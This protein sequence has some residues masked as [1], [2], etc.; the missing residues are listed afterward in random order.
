[1]IMISL[2]VWNST[3]SPPDSGKQPQRAIEASKAVIL[4]GL[5]SESPNLAFSQS[6]TN[7]L[8]AAGYEVDDFRGDNVT[9]DLL[10]NIANYS[11][12]IL[13]LHSTLDKYGNLYIFSGEPYT[14]SKYAME[15][16]T[17]SVRKA[18]TFDGKLYFALNVVLLGAKKQD[19]LKD[20][21]VILMGCN[22]TADSWGIRKL[23]E[24]GVK[25]YIAWTGYVDLSHSDDAT[26][27]LVKNLYVE[28]LSPAAAVEKTMAEAHPDP[29]YQTVYQCFV[30]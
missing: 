25:T 9:I 27:T 22:G 29:L 10:T 1:M 17:G 5:Y 24:R 11:V 12:V 30:R 28:K 13:R 3:N 16:L 23:H 6:L 7:Y 26:L 14:E 19:S 21:T 18:K 8:S 15:Q 2:V 20:S 4:D